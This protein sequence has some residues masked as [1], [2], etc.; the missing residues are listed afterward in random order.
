M[1]SVDTNDWIS[2]H[3]R[4]PFDIYSVVERMMKV[5][6]EKSSFHR[7]YDSDAMSELKEKVT[8]LMMNDTNDSYVDDG[9]ERF[10]VFVMN[11]DNYF[12]M[13]SMCLLLMV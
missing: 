8:W 11:L 13:E 10:P 1:R 3:V 5:W 4:Y 9:Y 2:I 12:S 7:I 6:Q